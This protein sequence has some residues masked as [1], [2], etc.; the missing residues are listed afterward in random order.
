ME[1]ENADGAHGD[2]SRRCLLAP[3]GV[4]FGYR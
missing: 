4:A 2:W 1:K 3:L